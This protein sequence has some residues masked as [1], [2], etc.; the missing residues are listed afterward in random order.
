MQKVETQ[1]DKVEN[2]SIEILPDI[3]AIKRRYEIIKRVKSEILT[4]EDYVKLSNGVEATGKSGWLKYGVAFALSYEIL[5][6]ERVPA[7]RDPEK[8]DEIFTYKITM[9]AW[10]PTHTRHADAVGSCTLKEKSTFT[11][12]HIVRAMADTRA[13]E[14]CIIKMLGTNE[15]AADDLP[16]NMTQDHATESD[17]CKCQGGTNMKDMSKGRCLTCKKPLKPVK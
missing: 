4:S 15:K 6:E 3:G 17:F 11:T 9:R 8:P 14:R 1:L 5:K 16:E 2:N 10:D 12:E 13:T 7:I